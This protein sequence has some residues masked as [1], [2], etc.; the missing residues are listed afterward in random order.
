ML[1][2]AL[3]PSSVAS[4]FILPLF[5]VNE[6]LPSIPSVD[7]VILIDVSSPSA[8]I[9]PCDDIPF[10]YCDARVIFAPFISISDAQ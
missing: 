10:L 9:L 8:V 5:I 3:S 4:I 6:V 1:V 7:F 2:P